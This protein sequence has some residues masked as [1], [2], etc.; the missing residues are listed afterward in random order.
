[1]CSPATND[2]QKLEILEPKLRTAE[3]AGER[4]AARGRPGQ[5]CTQCIA[6]A[7]VLGGVERDRFSWLAVVGKS[8]G[9]AGASLPFQGCSRN[10]PALPATELF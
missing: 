5:S 3:L 6:L 1:M 2:H 4:A 9:P 7:A 10:P 8:T